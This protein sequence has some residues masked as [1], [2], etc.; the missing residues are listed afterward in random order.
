MT[1]SRYALNEEFVRRWIT[2][3]RCRGDILVI[4]AFTVRSILC[5]IFMIF[6]PTAD[7]RWYF[8]VHSFGPRSGYTSKD[9]ADELVRNI[10]FSF[11]VGASVHD[12]ESGTTCFELGY[13]FVLLT[14]TH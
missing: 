7:I 8:H 4:V 9:Q 11:E 5:G 1:R 12:Y 10:K 3:A 13:N 2:F 6:P 14:I